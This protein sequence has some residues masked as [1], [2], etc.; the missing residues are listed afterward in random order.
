M[1]LEDYLKKEYMEYCYSNN[2]VI[3]E[4]AWVNEV[5]NNGLPRDDQLSYPSVNQ[6]MNGGREPDL[7]NAIRLIS[8]FG[9]EIVP[10][11][12]IKFPPDLEKVME[13]WDKTPPKKRKEILQILE[14]PEK[15]SMEV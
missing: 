15:E 14:D 4:S 6:W 3:G 5:L 10:H 9:P 8:V 7:K 11:L 1:Y 13:R 2:E 12:G